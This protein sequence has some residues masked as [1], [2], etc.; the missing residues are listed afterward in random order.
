[1]L[2]KYSYSLVFYKLRQTL[3]ILG[4][5]LSTNKRMITLTTD[6]HYIAIRKDI[7]AHWKIAL[8]NT[9]GTEK[10]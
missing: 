3:I 10:T 4:C 8:N 1:M 9:I 6:V 7:L 5:I 2:K